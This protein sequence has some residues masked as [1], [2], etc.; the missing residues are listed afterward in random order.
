MKK[1]KDTSLLRAQE[2]QEIIQKNKRDNRSLDLYDDTFKEALP[3]G[4]EH[5]FKSDRKRKKWLD[6]GCGNGC[7]LIE[8]SVKKGLSHVII[9]G[10]DIR[11]NIEIATKKGFVPNLQYSQQNLDHN[12]DLLLPKNVDLITALMIDRYLEDPLPMIISA[13]NSLSKGG[14]ML[15]TE[16]AFHYVRDKKY[17]VQ[18]NLSLHLKLELKKT[19]GDL[20]IVDA[21]NKDF[22]LGTYNSKVWIIKKGSKDINFDYELKD[23]MSLFGGGYSQEYLV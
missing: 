15:F 18:D 17:G 12:R 16:S 3:K 13:I 23:S 6:L 22:H 4:I 2:T 19:G 5:F 14:T 8:L 10:V 7:A 11:N 1:L 9:T 21:G 20:Q